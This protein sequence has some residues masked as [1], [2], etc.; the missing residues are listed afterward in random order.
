MVIAAVFLLALPAA[1]VTFYK[2]V[3]P[4]LQR[5]CESC[6]RPGEIGPMPLVTFAQVRPWAKAIRESV[7]MRRMP[8]WFADPRHGRFSND[9]SLSP[10]EIATIAA[11]VNEG[12]TEGI[13]REA[14][15]PRKWPEGWSV[16]SPDLVLTMP[17]A[18]P[19]PANTAIEYQ[20]L[21]LP[22][23]FTSDRWVR[24]V[25]I[26]P[27]NPAVVHHAVLY[28]REPASEWLRGAKPGVMFAP[29]ATDFDAKRNA[30]DTKADILAVYTPG[31]PAA[32]W[33]AGMAKH[34]PAGSDLV[35]QMHFTSLK[36]TTEERTQ[37]GLLPAT[38]RS[39]HRVITL[40]MGVDDIVIPPGAR[41]FRLSRSGTMPRDALL[42]SMFPHMHLRGSGFEYQIVGTGGRVETLLKV[43]RYNFSWQLAYHLQ[44]PR[45]LPAGTQLLWTGYFD[46]SANNPRNPNPAAEVRWGEQSW[47][48]MMIGF[49]DVAVP[50]EMDKRT[51]FIRR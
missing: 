38:E 47:E 36:E 10:A 31:A 37:I 19:V 16:S 24:L 44:T 35:L 18:F 20:Y 32:T 39:T 5:R 50:A 43:D 33:P 12:S 27:S 30:R 28:V 8:P 13:K 15:P 1:A 7:E 2:D 41:D 6:H 22:T 14:P 26:R 48:E 17:E 51:F 21:I 4:I 42:L 29:P 11:W 40:Q 49:F 34:I 46:N 3:A 23:Q 9:P 45:L 25:E